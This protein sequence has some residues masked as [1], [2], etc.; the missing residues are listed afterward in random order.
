MKKYIPSTITLLNLTCGFM[1]IIL[2]D[3]LWSPILIGVGGLLD[4]FDGFLAKKISAISDLGKQLDSLADL[5]TF[6]IAPAFLYY[7]HILME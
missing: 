4:F 2:N 6:G 1:A 7:Q 3:I 5:V